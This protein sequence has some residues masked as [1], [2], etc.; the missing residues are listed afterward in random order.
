MEL[1]VLGEG[2]RLYWKVRDSRAKRPGKGSQMEMIE[3]TVYNTGSKVI[4]VLLKC[5]T[6]TATTKITQDFWGSVVQLLSYVRLF[7]TSSTATH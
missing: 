7:S 6:G 3:R 5:V 4:Q 1:K 2:G